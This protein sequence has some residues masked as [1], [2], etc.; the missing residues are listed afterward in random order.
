MDEIVRNLKTQFEDVSDE[1]LDVVNA[2]EQDL[3]LFRDSMPLIEYMTKEA[4]KVKDSN[5]KEIK[6]W[7]EVF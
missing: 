5:K 3:D 7:K 1:A 2:F 4:M 6:Y